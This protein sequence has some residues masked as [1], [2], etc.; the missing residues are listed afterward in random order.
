[1]A[2]TRS[3]PL[4]AVV[5][6]VALLLAL[7]ALASASDVSLSGSTLVIQGTPGPDHISFGG[8]SLLE[9]YVVDTA[10]ITAGAGCRQIDATEAECP[11]FESGLAPYTQVVAHLGEGDDF[12]AAGILESPVTV[13]GE[14]GNDT[15]F[16]GSGNDTVL[17]GAGD[18][19]I[20]GNGGSDT[21]DGGPGSD[22]VLGGGGDDHVIGGPGRDSINGDGPEVLDDGND[23]IDA[24]DGEQDQVQCGFGA[25]VVN[26]DRADVV[27]TGSCE[28]VRLVA[29]PPPKGG[30][31]VTLRS[32]PA[33]PVIATVLRRGYRFTT[34]VSAAAG[35]SA[36]L[37]V[38]KA[39]ARRRHI[40]RS[41]VDIAKRTGSV[42]AGRRTITLKVASR[43]RTAVRRARRIVAHLIVAVADGAGHTDSVVKAVTLVR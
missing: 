2:H 21:V 28:S 27:D 39:E 41:G 3:T 42:R 26:A 37:Y 23:T 32:A 24:A 13:D 14:G 43:Y 16:A 17:G 9:K 19:Q 25:D 6:A 8:N 12:F 30:L 4:A 20:T 33:R 22:T 10:G 36:A 18:D 5:G 34:S 7:P 35:Y 1:M 40:A 11:S 29:A 15:I 38:T 31:S